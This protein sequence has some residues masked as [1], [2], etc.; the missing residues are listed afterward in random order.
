MTRYFAGWLVA[1]AL[2][3]SAPGQAWTH[4]GS[5]IGGWATRRL[6]VIVNPTGCPLSESALYD[7]IDN[8]ISTW[9]RVPL[10]DLTLFRDPTPSNYT[11][12]D[13][14]LGT[15]VGAPLI[16][17]DTAFSTT[18][19]V[20]ADFVPAATRAATADDGRLNAAVIGLNAEVGTAAEISDIDRE[21]MIVILAHEIG[22]ALGL[23]HSSIAEALMYYSVSGKQEALL[24]QDDMD[25]LAIL[26]P[27]NELQAG[28]FGCSAVHPPTTQAPSGALLAVGWLLVLIA[29]GR[30]AMPSPKSDLD[31]FPHLWDRLP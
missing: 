25:G 13:F 22:H 14:D 8:A 27:R 11:N 26:Y 16:Y 20:D 24:A 17:C 10:V 18:Y 15:V 30:R 29:L 7:I 28:A 12:T 19:S 5:N 2:V 4:I 9:N 1:I 3:I 6:S 31:H 21:L 23:G